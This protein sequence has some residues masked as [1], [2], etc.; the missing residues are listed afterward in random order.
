[1]RPGLPDQIA[2]QSTRNNRVQP[3]CVDASLVRSDSKFLHDN[4]LVVLFLHSDVV[5]DPLISPGQ[6]RITTITTP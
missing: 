1:M 3:R 4:W 2:R 5:F 6:T